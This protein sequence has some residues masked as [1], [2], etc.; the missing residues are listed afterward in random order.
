MLNSSG[1]PT[2]PEVQKLP[3]INNAAE[4]HSQAVGVRVYVTE[5]EPSTV[6]SACGLV[7]ATLRGGLLTV[8]IRLAVA[9]RPEASPTVTLIV[10][11]PLVRVRVSHSNG[12]N[13]AW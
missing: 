3:S 13:G 11:R 4:I 10:W 2:V 1:S 7:I 6:A 12:P 9:V 8:T 5:T